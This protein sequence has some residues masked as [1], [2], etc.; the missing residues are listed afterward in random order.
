MKTKF[1]L[2]VMIIALAMAL[3]TGASNSWF[4]DS[5]AVESN[6]FKAAEDFEAGED[7]VPRADEDGAEHGGNSGDAKGGDEGKNN[8][9]GEP[10]AAGDGGN[11]EEEGSRGN[12]PGGDGG[13]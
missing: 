12:G 5:A 3:V 11:D 9:P 2:S 8:E 7:D 4:T 13:N 1:L 6:T 10:P